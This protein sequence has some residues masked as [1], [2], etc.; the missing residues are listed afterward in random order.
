MRRLEVVTRHLVGRPEMLAANLDSVRAMDASPIHTILHDDE[1]RGVA[2]ANA[3]MRTF[4]PVGDYVWMLDD[5][6]KAT[7]THLATCINVLADL[8]EPDLIMI[9][10]HHGGTLGILPDETDWTHRNPPRLGGLGVSSAIVSKK[11]WMACRHAWGERYEGDF[12]FIS[13]AFRSARD[14]LWHNCI[15]SRCQRTL[16]GGAPE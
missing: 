5:D 13:E 2:W 1:G 7:C 11:H 4:T 16:S 8:Y 3:Q 10:M 14:I 6:D 9:R 12:D 15:A